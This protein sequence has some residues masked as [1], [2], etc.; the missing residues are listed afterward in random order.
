MY[1]YKSLEHWCQAFDS[2]ILFYEEWWART[3]ENR[4]IEGLT[5]FP[6]GMPPRATR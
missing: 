4:R 2:S 5:P 3:I 6:I 1:D